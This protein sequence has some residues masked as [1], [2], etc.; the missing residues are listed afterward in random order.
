I[1]AVFSDNLQLIITDSFGRIFHSPVSFLLAFTGVFGSIWRIILSIFR[2]FQKMSA[3]TD[4]ALALLRASSGH[5]ENFVISPFSLGAALAIVH[6]G[7]KEDTQK[8]LTTLLGKTLSPAEVSALYSSLTAALSEKNSAV[9]TNVANRFFLDKE[10]TLKAEYQS[11][12]EKVFNAGAENINFK[13]GDGSANHVNAF[14]EKNTGGMIP[15]LVEAS[16]FGGNAVAVL[17]NAVYFKGEWETQFNKDATQTKPFHGIAGDRDEKFMIANKLNTRYSLNDDLTVVS[18]AYKDPS[19]SL[20]VLMPS[21]DFGEWR[22]NL[23]AETLQG[24]IENLQT[25]KI[26]LELPKFKIESTTD[27]KAALKKC[28]VKRI[29]E[30]TADLSGIS[31]KDLYVSKIVHKAVI[32]VTEEGTEATAATGIRMHVKG[33]GPLTP[34]LTFNRPCIYAIVKNKKIKKI[35]KQILFIGQKA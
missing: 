6:D 21:G 4:F 14:V 23:T 30:D 13:D 16:A 18:L 25:G 7:A 1:T 27:G 33:L 31:D 28:G 34:E 10:F 11:H 2:L 5:A 9:I 32:E 35:K 15:K 19:Y 3:S 29:F 26:N 8:E 20:V 17:I 12:V 22:A 24:A